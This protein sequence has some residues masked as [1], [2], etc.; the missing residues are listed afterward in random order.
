M[1][2]TGVKLRTTGN[3]CHHSG[4]GCASALRARRPSAVHP[5]VVHAVRA[6]PRAPAD[7]GPVG[8]HRATGASSP[9]RTSVSQ[10]P[11]AKRPA[12]RGRL[13]D[14]WQDPC[15]RQDHQSTHPKTLLVDDRPHRCNNP[16]QSDA[17]RTRS[18]SPRGLPM[19]SVCSVT[20]T[21]PSDAGPARH[22]MRVLPGPTPFPRTL[23]ASP[24]RSE[25]PPWQAKT[26]SR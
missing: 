16:P 4:S 12:P 10:G 22:S 23:H 24:S 7:R 3:D 11:G 5:P 1:A 6:E 18:G 9:I 21:A 26:S 14:A 19:T 8:R 25:R 17:R 2:G 13:P 15:H 20:G